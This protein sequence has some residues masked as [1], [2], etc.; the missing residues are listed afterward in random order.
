MEEVWLGLSDPVLIRNSL[1][2]C[3]FLLEVDDESPD[4]EELRDRA[5]EI[6]DEDVDLDPEAV[7]ERAFQEGSRYVALM[8]ISIGPVN[9]SFETT[10]E[11]LHR[12]FPEMRAEGEGSASNSSFDVEAGMRLSQDGDDVIVE[13]WAEADVFGRIAQMGQRMIN[14]VANR[15]INQFFNSVEAQLDGLDPETSSSSGGLTTSIKS[16]LGM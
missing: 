3:Q 10:V 7:A 11:N 2:G 4:F 14:P 1:P 5:A 15:V 9:P 12:E 6:D 8:E 13:W 16:R